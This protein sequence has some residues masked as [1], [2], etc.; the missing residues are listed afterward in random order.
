MNIQRAGY[1]R[2]KVDVGWE[3]REKVADEGCV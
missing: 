1:R 2:W 3:P